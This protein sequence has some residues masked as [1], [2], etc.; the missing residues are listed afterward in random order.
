MSIYSQ[1]RGEAAFPGTAATSFNPYGRNSHFT[2][3]IHDSREK[4]SLAQDDY[5]HNIAGVKLAATNHVGSFLSEKDALAVFKA[6]VRKCAGPT[7]LV[8][9]AN[10]LYDFDHSRDG[11]LT[12]KEF[13]S[14][15]EAMRINATPREV[16]E[17]LAY[18][19]VELNGKI[20]IEALRESLTDGALPA[21]RAALVEA[22]YSTLSHGG[23]LNG[24]GAGG[25]SGARAGGR[26]QDLGST[27]RGAGAAGG[28]EAFV[29]FYKS[30]SA[31]MNDEAEFEEAVRR[32]YRQGGGTDGGGA[33][34]AG[35]GAGAG[36][37]GGVRVQVT[38]NDSTQEVIT[39]PPQSGVTSSD[40][41]L[42]RAVLRK[43]GVRNVH[44][45][46]VL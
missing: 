15:L 8:D 37:G 43:Q 25:G 4:H 39:L 19:D 40:I 16:E 34:G 5:S 22:A 18:Y 2:N 41:P 21:R 45:I 3:D 32:A 23:M 28:K 9:L 6:R 12:L 35:G 29:D 13:L 38:H 17:L 46:K 14:A 33:A 27:A 31:M 36:A 26:R 30:V 24:G 7:G 11:Q 10:T 42:I 44:S 20:S 1:R